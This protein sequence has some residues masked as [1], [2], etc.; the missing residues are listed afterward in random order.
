MKIFPCGA[1]HLSE[2]GSMFFISIYKYSAVV[3]GSAQFAQSAGNRKEARARNS[4]LYA[5]FARFSDKRGSWKNFV[6]HS[7]K[8]Q[9]IIIIYLNVKFSS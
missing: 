9:H 6:T 2:D 5:L 8:L 3:T 4:I 7:G 1:C